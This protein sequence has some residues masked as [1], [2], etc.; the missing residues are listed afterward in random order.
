[1]TAEGGVTVL[2]QMILRM[3]NREQTFRELLKKWKQ[4][5]V[6]GMGCH[7]RP[8]QEK[9]C[10]ATFEVIRCLG[11]ELPGRVIQCSRR[12]KRDGLCWQHLRVRPKVRRHR[13][14]AGGV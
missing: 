1:M 6:T 2:L 14:Q 9:R 5:G 8:A 4:K 11:F 10:K 7:R 3:K 13:V 12:V